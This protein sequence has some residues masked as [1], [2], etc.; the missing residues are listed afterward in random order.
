MD[1]DTQA[2]ENI[3]TYQKVGK[4]EEPWILEYV[5]EERNKKKTWEEI[6]G[7]LKERGQVTITPQI[8]STLHKKALARTLTTSTTAKEDFIEFTEQLREIY[9]DAIKLMGEYVRALRTIN[10]ELG[11]I[12]VVDE[13]GKVNVLQT[14]MAIGKQIPLA[15]GLMKEVRE[16]VKNQIALYDVVQET[17][18]KDVV[19]SENQMLNYIEQ[20]LPI[21]IKEKLKKLKNEYGDTIP[22]AKLEKELVNGFK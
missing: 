14:Q 21:M 9:G 11:K 17:K 15:T 6:A 22:L 20:Y 3:I 16:Y 2:H 4:H 7:G 5:V 8:C 19:W 1:E 13:D 12:A 18:E 10:E